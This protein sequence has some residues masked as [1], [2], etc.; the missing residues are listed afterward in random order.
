MNNLTDIIKT[1]LLDVRIAAKRTLFA[2][3][4]YFSNLWRSLIGQTEKDYSQLRN[5]LIEQANDL[6][7]KNIELQ[8]KVDSLTKKVGK[9]TAAVAKKAPAKKKASGK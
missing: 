2:V 1:F 7:S 5:S 3:Q 8:R 6:L 4:V 9:K